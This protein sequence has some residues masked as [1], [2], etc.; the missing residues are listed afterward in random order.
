MKELTTVFDIKFPNDNDIIFNVGAEY[1]YQMKQ[2]QIAGR[3]GFDSSNDA[4]S[5]VTFGLGIKLNKI[6]NLKDFQFDYAFV[7]YGDLDNSHRVS[8]SVKF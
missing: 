5:G 6:S 1:V 2:G 4:G 3:M 8:L 7:P